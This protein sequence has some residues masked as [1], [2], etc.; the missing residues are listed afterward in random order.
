MV[1][2]IKLLS[3]MLCFLLI[4]F[5]VG[6]SS[7]FGPKEYSDQQF[8]MDTL[9]NIEAYGQ[10]E[11]Q[12]KAAV[13]KAYQEM[14]KIAL[15]TDRFAK[16]GTA[17]YEQSEVV[18]IN[19][20]AGKK[21][22]QV[23]EDV[24]EMIEMSLKYERFS[25]GAFDITIGPLMDIWGFGKK[26]KQ[27]V[28]PASLIQ[29]KLSLVDSDQVFLNKDNRTVF[30]AKPKMSIDLGAIAKGY[31]AEKAAEV[32]KQ[33]G[34]KQ[35][36]INAGGNVVVIGKK[37]QDNLWRIGI[38]DPRDTQ[39]VVG[40]LSLEDEATVTSGDYQRNFV[41]NGVLYHHILSPKTGKPA[42]GTWSV[43]VIA[44]SSALADVLSTTLFVLG[45]EEG[46]KFV[47]KLDGVEAFYVGADKKIRISSGLKNKVTVQAG[48]KYSYDQGR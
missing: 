46:L 44:K 12:L 2:P 23:S 38:E 19:N 36:L 35:A 40:I 22:V 13:D 33:A 30:L 34:I 39:N 9:I 37:D 15:L 26:E 17:A 21:P 24:Y 41:E 29:E 27:H 3:I 45:P 16:P 10:N 1:K 43:T 8:L 47:E 6:C 11:K 7:L 28:P 14:N 31:A 4:P 5:L 18:K 42:R 32:L 20:A 25:G 48:K